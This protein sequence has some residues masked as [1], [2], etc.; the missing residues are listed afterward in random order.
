MKLSIELDRLRI[1]AFHGVGAQERSVGNM[2]EVSVHMRVNGALD[3]ACRDE[4]ARTVNYA[5]V[6]QAVKEEMS[7]PSRLIENVCV[8]VVRRI[9]ADFPQVEGGSVTVAKLMP[10]V[11]NC[12]LENVSATI[13]W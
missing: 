8:R 3:G 6:I 5:D 4:L 11:P 1:R 12:C 13:E 10:P 7:Q 9:Q 2:F